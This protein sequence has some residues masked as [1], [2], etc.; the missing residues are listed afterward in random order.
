M[1]VER[2]DLYTCDISSESPRFTFN[3]VTKIK[4]TPP[5]VYRSKATRRA[6]VRRP[7][8]VGGDDQGSSQTLGKEKMKRANGDSCFKQCSFKGSVKASQ[9]SS[10]IRTLSGRDDLELRLRMIFHALFQGAGLW[11]PDCSGWSVPGVFCAI[12]C[13]RWWLEEMSSPKWNS[14]WNSISCVSPRALGTSGSVA[15]SETDIVRMFHPDSAA[16]SL[17]PRIQR[18]WP[19]V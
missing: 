14:L 5:S 2:G 17:G 11:S 19:G 4:I 12:W 7:L 16:P 6:D 18:R 15:Y 8:I 9:S 3:T 1:S 10:L 13:Q